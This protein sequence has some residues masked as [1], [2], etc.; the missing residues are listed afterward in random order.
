[1]DAKGA[2]QEGFRIDDDVIIARDTIIPGLGRGSLFWMG[3]ELER[4]LVLVLEYP[5]KF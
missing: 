1:L 4:V 2:G 5:Q 3:S